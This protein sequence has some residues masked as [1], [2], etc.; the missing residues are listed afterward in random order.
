MDIN[1]AM[2][3]KINKM[4]YKIQLIVFNIVTGHC[5]SLI[6]LIC[7]ITEQEKPL[8]KCQ[9]LTIILIVAYCTLYFE[10]KFIEI[11]NLCHQ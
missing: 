10:M 5:I 2:G 9:S 8:L 4:S 1:T 11:K 6:S 7:L 3:K